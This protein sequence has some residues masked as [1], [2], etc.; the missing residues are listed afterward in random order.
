[1]LALEH[2]VILSSFLF[3]FGL[4]GALARRN[5]V[6]VL[7]SIELM[8]QAVN[9]NFVAFAMYLDPVRV[10]GQIITVFVICIAAA[11]VALALAILL[12]I[13][14]NRGT[15]NLDDINLMKW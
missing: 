11:E 6:L 10:S 13:F 8:L 12:R 15:I 5:G 3:G 1:M 4:Y 14:R 9:I 2:F 7:M